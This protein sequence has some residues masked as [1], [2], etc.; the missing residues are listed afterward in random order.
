MSIS[1]SC[2]KMSIL[3]ARTP[4]GSNPKDLMTE[5]SMAGGGRCECG[6]NGENDLIRNAVAWNLV[7][8]GSK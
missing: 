6:K 5:Q 1:C 3:S 7:S 4:S 2:K 8:I